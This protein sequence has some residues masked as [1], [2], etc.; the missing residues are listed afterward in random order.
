MLLAMVRFEVREVRGRTTAAAAAPYHSNVDCV[1]DITV[2]EIMT[3]WGYRSGCFKLRT[4][5]D[6]SIMR[7][8][9]RAQKLNGP[10]RV[11]ARE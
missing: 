9:I 5:R 6:I 3:P 4:N 7:F 11:E 1:K 10:D 8:S 2:R